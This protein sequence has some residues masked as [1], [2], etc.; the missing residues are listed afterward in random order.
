M[1]RLIPGATLCVRHR[2]C[3]STPM[4]ILAF[5]D[6]VRW[7]GYK[8]LIAE[9]QP[10]VVALAGDLTSDGGAAFW[11]DAFEAIPEYRAAKRDELHRLG[12]SVRKDDQSDIDIIRG[13]SLKDIMGV[14]D[15]LKRSFQETPEFK[16]ARRKLHTNRFY[17]FLKFAGQTAIVLVV[18]GDHD[19]D[20]FGDYQSRRINRIEGC[21]EISGR[22]V[23]VGGTTFLGL[24]YDQA[25]L[26]RPLREFVRRYQGEVDVVI[27]HPPH[28][29]V[30][31][32]AELRPQLLVRGHSGGGRYLINDVPTVFTC[33]GHALIDLSSSHLPTIHASSSSETYYLERYDWLSRYPPN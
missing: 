31:I 20:F 29:N 12:I 1:R 15:A 24:G 2:N 3:D 4:R 22:T 23:I 21:H 7:D 17:S 6:V 13:G 16:K 19:D 27:A 33:F 25:A 14:E 5:S 11:S 30:P 10:Q 26:R 32:I 28:R 18:K 8:A 9:H